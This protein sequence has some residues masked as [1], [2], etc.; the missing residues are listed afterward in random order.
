LK[1]SYG[2]LRGS[3]D[4]APGLTTQLNDL[5]G[6]LQPTVPLLLDNLTSV[7]QVTKVYLPGIRQA[8][9]VLPADI[10]DLASAIM[11]S[12]VP[13]T[14]NVNF[15]LQETNAC[16]QGYQTTMRQ[17]D[18]TGPRAAPAKTPY[19]TAA[20][21]SQQNVRGARNDPCPNN[22]SLRSATA[23]GCGLYFGTSGVPA[24]ESGGGASSYDPSSGLLVGPNGLMYSVG[25]NT[26]SGSGPS[27]LQ[28]LLKE[29]LGS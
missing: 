23:A 13:G 8:L 17:P 18:S 25:P 2:D 26:V 21:S 7:G 27:T 29:T 16:T 24:G 3:L 1:K 12:P 19:C 5:I 11:T 20:H 15:K 4:Q 22:P 9:V 14:S 10:N 6:Q 28:G